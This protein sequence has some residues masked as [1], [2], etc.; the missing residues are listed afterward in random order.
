MLVSC[1]AATLHELQTVYSVED[2][3][4]LLEIL[5]VDRYNEQRLRKFHERERDQ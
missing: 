5:L 4:D 3:Y 1:K 2:M